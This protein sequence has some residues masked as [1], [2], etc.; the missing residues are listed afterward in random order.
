MYPNPDEGDTLLSC[1]LVDDPSHTLPK[2]TVHIPVC[3]PS[4]CGDD[5]F[6]PDLLETEPATPAPVCTERTLS[7]A[8]IL[9]DLSE[10]CGGVSGHNESAESLQLQLEVSTNSE[11]QTQE[12]DVENTQYEDQTMETI[13]PD[14]IV[15]GVEDI[16]PMLFHPF[17]LYMRKQVATT[18]N[19]N[20]GRKYGFGLRVDALRYHGTGEQCTGNFHVHT[21]D[22]D[23][24]CFFR[25]ISYLL[26]GSEA[27]HDVVRNAVCN[28]IIQPENWYK[29]K[30]Y[31]DG[32]I[33]G[34]EE[35]VRKSEMH[36]WGKWATHVELLALAQLTSKDVCVYTLDLWMRYSA[37]RTSKRPTKNAFYLTNYHNVHFDPVIV[38]YP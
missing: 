19:I 29:L 22:G 18:V 24:N 37:S 30:V 20:V 28:Y 14:L 15:N 27:K 4:S 25:S 8:E 7:A 3:T 34:S 36:V 23:G 2:L 10:G 5:A 33:T 17:S 6:L 11:Q 12:V 9:A 38:V 26:L 13:D 1:T 35:Y 31:I 32:D 21:V 16:K